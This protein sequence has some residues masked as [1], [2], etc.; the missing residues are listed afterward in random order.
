MTRAS[1]V[2][3]L[4]LASALL[5]HYECDAA[6]DDV[7]WAISHI[8]ELEARIERLAGALEQSAS[9]LYLISQHEDAKRIRGTALEWSKAA[10]SAL[11]GEPT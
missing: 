8:A 1:S 5:Y 2:D 6:G 3:Q 4:K 10:R 7:E 11:S 9:R